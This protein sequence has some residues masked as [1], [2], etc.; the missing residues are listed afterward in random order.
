MQNKIST[1]ATYEEVMDYLN[2]FDEV[3]DMLLE[4]LNDSAP[5]ITMISQNPTEIFNENFIDIVDF[6][7]TEGL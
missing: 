6:L 1:Q 7:S 3:D 5:Q 2:T 4:F